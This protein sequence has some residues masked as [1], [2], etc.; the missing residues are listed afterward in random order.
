M[1]A[2]LALAVL[3]AALV[4]V[5]VVVL[6][7]AAAKAEAFDFDDTPLRAYVVS[8]PGTRSRR[9]IR[10]RFAEQNQSISFFD[11]VDGTTLPD[12]PRLKPGEVG[13]ATSHMRLWEQRPY[14]DD[15]D[16]L[17]FEDDAMLSADFQTRLRRVRREIHGQDV[18]VVF[19]GHC[20][21][22]EGGAWMGSTTLRESV[23]PLCTHGYLLTARGAQKLAEWASRGQL[24]DPI[25]HVLAGMC[26]NQTLACLSCYPPLVATTQ[27]T[28]IIHA[29]TRPP[30]GG[31]GGGGGG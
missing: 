26:N 10:A 7:Q 22:T 17:I 2:R 21:E 19:L 11:G 27:E 20:F 13:C 24:D 8:M 28:S 5:V 29:L 25:D 12:H 3:A 15:K 31:G 16:V 9:L 4:V 30:G 1:A 18:D 14:G 6:H 23:R